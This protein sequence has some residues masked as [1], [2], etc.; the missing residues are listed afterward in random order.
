MVRETT[1][2]KTRRQGQTEAPTAAAIAT[3]STVARTRTHAAQGLIITWSQ[4]A[5]VAAV[6]VLLNS[7]QCQGERSFYKWS[8]D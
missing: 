6:A 3:T 1:S 7:S 4:L 2:W 5:V 8:Y